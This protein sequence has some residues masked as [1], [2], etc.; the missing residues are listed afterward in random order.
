ML[1]LQQALNRLPRLPLAQ[2]PTPLQHAPRLSKALGGPEIYFKRDDLTGMPL[3]GNKTR[4]FEF[5]MPRALATGAD[6]VVAGA[7]V[8]S[9]YC[10]QM[11]AACA[12]LGL[13]VYLLLR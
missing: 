6:C 10:R 9:N 1:Q 4:M 13:D 2:L 5:V 7:A 11:T 8:Q 3:G 12:K